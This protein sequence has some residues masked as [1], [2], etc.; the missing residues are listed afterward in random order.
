MPA[1]DCMDSHEIRYDEETLQPEMW[2]DLLSSGH[3][4]EEEF[5]I[6]PKSLRSRRNRRGE[7]TSL[8]TPPPRNQ[9][10][11]SPQR[12][13]RYAKRGLYYLPANAR[14]VVRQDYKDQPSRINRIHNMARGNGETVI[15]TGP[16]ISPSWRR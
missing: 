6:L 2:I 16:A 4:D 10:P 7:Y 8:P 3:I 1:E 15:H 14:A 5:E 12:P 11:Q 13:I 9:R